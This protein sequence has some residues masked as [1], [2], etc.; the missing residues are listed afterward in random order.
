MAKVLLV[1]PDQILAQTIAG[2]LI[3]KGFKVEVAAH[4]EAA[5]QIIEKHK[6]SLVVLQMELP[7][8]SGLEFMYE[9]RSYEPWLKIPVIAMS[10]QISEAPAKSSSWQH[11]NFAAWLYWPTSSLE[12]LLVN[13][14]QSLNN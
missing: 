14:N 7:K 11:L 10:A 4:A 13:I 9:F 1:Q 8:H 12:E 3:G 5:M 6:P 2:F